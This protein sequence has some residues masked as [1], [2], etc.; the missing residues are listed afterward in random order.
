MTTNQKRLCSEQGMI[1]FTSL[2][3]LSIL[4]MVGIGSR[5]MLQ[6]DFRVLTNLRGGTEAFYFS[7]A[8]LAWSKSEIARVKTFPPTPAGRSENFSSGSFSVSFLSPSAIG[9]L[10][11]KIVV[12]SI[13]TIGSASHTIQAQLT[14]TYDL[15]DAA[16]GLR[17]NGSQVN[18]SGNGILISGVDHDPVTGNPKPTGKPR[19]AVTG[20]D[21]SLLALVN[22]AAGNL[23][24]GSLES[25]GSTAVTATSEN[26]SSAMV[27]QLANSLCT[28]TTAVV[29]VV[30]SGGAIAYENQTWGSRAGPQLRCI[31][32]LSEAGDAV[33]LSEIGGAGILVVRNS[34]LILSGSL[35]WE[36]LV[37]VT[38]G[39]VSFKATGSASK[40]ILGGVIV[41]ETGSSNGGK[42]ILDIQGNL[43][44]LFSRQGLAQAAALISPTIL[45]N[46][47]A[48][49]PAM[50]TQDY[51]RTV[52]P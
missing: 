28:L 31:D 44:L 19:V 10:S 16:I 15:T 4:L 13:G 5:I 30:P 17:G 1:L 27:T 37:I 52:T 47:Y 35:R 7:E 48:S 25:G 41:N 49:L 43:R 50:I 51:W 2:A 40:E 26:L 38:G 33:T 32:G 46:S 34:D 12:R 8:G 39:D 24:P 20:G 36:G 6:N 18:L 11:A 3:I 23:S 21:D 14:K 45:S 9:P 22:N 42:A 29:S